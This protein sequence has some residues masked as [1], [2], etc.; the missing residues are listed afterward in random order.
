MDRNLAD[1]IPNVTPVIAPVIARAHA[2]IQTLSHCCAATL[3]C[4]SMDD[5]F[6]FTAGQSPLLVSLPHDGTS[7]PADIA[8]RMTPVALDTPDTDWHVGRLYNF[9]GD[10]GASV[11]S[12]I[13]IGR[14]MA[15]HCIAL[16]AIPSW[17]H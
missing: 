11:M 12:S 4:V 3:I 6:S 1:R 17:C 5:L 9:A 16:P 14:R 10:L 8:A 15:R 7:I 13:L 2:G